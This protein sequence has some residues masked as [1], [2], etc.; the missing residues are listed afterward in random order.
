MSSRRRSTIPQRAPAPE[1]PVASK[2][3]EL[4][5]RISRVE[6]ACRELERAL[7]IALKRVTALQAHLDHLTAKLTLK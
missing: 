1:L 3:L 4:E 7:E 5:Q 6:A 2:T